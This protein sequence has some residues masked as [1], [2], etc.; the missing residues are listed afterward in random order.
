MGQLAE[1]VSVTAETPRLQ[2]ETREVGTS[3]SNKQLIRLPLSFSSVRSP[4]N[5]AHKIT[6]GVNGDFWQSHVPS[7]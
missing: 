1:S 3:I 7:F 5:F 4:E 2:S 6:P